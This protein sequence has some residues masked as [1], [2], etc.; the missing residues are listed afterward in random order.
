MPSVTKYGLFSSLRE[1]GYFIKSVNL[2]ASAIL[3]AIRKIIF[4]PDHLDILNLS[5]LHVCALRMKT[6]FISIRTSPAKRNAVFNDWKNEHLIIQTQIPAKNYTARVEAAEIKCQ[7]LAVELKSTKL[8]LQQLKT[9]HVEKLGSSEKKIEQLRTQHECLKALKKTPSRKIER[10]EGMAP[11]T[12]RRKKR[13]FLMYMKRATGKDYSVVEKLTP[14]KMS[15]QI[16]RIGL[17]QRSYAK[18]NFSFHFLIIHVPFV[19]RKRVLCVT[20]FILYK[21]IYELFIIHLQFKNRHQP[22]LL[23]VRRARQKVNTKAGDIKCI[24]RRFLETAA[25]ASSLT[26]LENG[27]EVKIAGDGHDVQRF[28]KF[29]TL[30]VSLVGSQK[31][32]DIVPLSVIPGQESYDSLSQSQFFSVLKD[33]MIPNIEYQGKTFDVRYFFGG[34]LKFI[35][36]CLGMKAAN[37]RNSCIYCRCDKSKWH[38]CLSSVKCELRFDPSVM[39]LSYT[40]RDA[41]MKADCLVPI[42]KFEFVMLDTMHMFFRVTDQLFRRALNFADKKG[43]AAFEK[44]CEEKKISSFYLKCDDV[45]GVTFSKLTGRAR[46]IMLRDVFCTDGLPRFIPAEH[47]RPI[48]SVFEA[49]KVLWDRISVAVCSSVELISAIEQFISLFRK[50]F[51]ISEIPDYVHLLCHLPIL[52]DRFGNATAFQQQSGEQTNFIVS[53][54]IS[55]MTTPAAAGEQATR[56]CCRKL[57]YYEND[58]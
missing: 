38:T 21:K 41:G 14:R 52:V 49:F 56:A 55:S 9:H 53:K 27:L 43:I 1:D 46:N 19:R 51:A 18:V 44:L 26:K 4:L 48:L 54:V 2:P 33:A 47:V 3:S 32:S 12:I 30:T 29:V 8:E 11:S 24:L 45:A 25:A 15:L 13:D 34:D 20:K 5:Q 23:A 58:E 28:R 35:L 42:G 31:M 17:S 22:A 36:S 57:F 39:K 7:Q 10:K 50:V 37:S 16:E 6:K 40:K